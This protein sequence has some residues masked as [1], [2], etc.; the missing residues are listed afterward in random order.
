M[1][2][3]SLICSKASDCARKPIVWATNIPA[4]GAGLLGSRA[5][6][7]WASSRA[8]EK[9]AVVAAMSPRPPLAST[10]YWPCAIRLS[11]WIIRV[12]T[13]DWFLSSW[14]SAR[15]RCSAAASS[16]RAWAFSRLIRSSACWVERMLP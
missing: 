9:G 4:R 6:A 2:R 16:C 8:S 15:I 13:V 3:Y 11:N 12:L 10:L 7:A 1:K 14:P 5:R